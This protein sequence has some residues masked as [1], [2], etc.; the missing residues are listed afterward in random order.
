MYYDNE[1]LTDCFAEIQARMVYLPTRK[2][3]DFFYNIYH[4]ENFGV[5]E[6]SKFKSETKVP[7]KARAKNFIMLVRQRRR[8]L[9]QSFW[10]IM[11]LKNAGLSFL[12]RPYGYYMFRRFNRE[13][14][15]RG[16]NN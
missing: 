9:M 15:L 1:L 5:F 13:R 4:F 3:I 10:S 11:T 7:L 6:F 16:A 14:A 8:F 12:V 2:Q